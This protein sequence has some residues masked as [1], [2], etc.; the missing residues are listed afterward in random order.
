MERSGAIEAGV[1]GVVFW[2]STEVPEVDGDLFRLKTEEVGSAMFPLRHL[3]E[4]EEGRGKKS[5]QCS[6][7]LLQLRKMLLY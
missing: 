4:R 2:V 6:A 5:K 3:H 1:N 7:M